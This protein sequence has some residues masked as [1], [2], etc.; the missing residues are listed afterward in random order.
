MLN[1]VLK[2]RSVAPQDVVEIQTRLN[3]LKYYNAPR[4]MPL[5]AL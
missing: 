3:S 1:R 5:E 2:P 4:D